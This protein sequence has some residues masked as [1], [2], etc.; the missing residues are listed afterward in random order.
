MPSNASLEGRLLA[1]RK[2]LIRLVAALPDGSARDDVIAFLHDRSQVQD[3]E[4]DPGVV[5][6]DAM[7]IEGALSDELRLILEGVDTPRS[8]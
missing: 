3:H 7:S 6:G 1:Q 2:V 5:P 4:E 8:S